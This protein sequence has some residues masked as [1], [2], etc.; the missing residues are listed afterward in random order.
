[1]LLVKYSKTIRQNI[2]NAALK[3]WYNTILFFR[4]ETI[5]MVL[6]LNKKET[7]F[8][9]YCG[10]QILKEAVICVNC[11]MQVEEL[12]RPE[13]IIINNSNINP[14]ITREKNKWISLGLCIFLGILGAHK[15]YERK[16]GVG[17]LYI[18]TCGLFGIGVIFDIFTLLFKPNPYY[19]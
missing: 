17:I 18:F 3:I 12:K 4:K 11:G 8:C 2:R 1:M 5:N 6:N 9:K 16:T 10:K 14:R 19:I 7:K 15:F 13:K